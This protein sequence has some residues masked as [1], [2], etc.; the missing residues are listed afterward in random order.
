MVVWPQYL[1]DAPSSFEE[2]PPQVSI[3]SP[4]AVGLPKTRRLYTSNVRTFRVV[5]MFTWRQL[6]DFKA[7]Y[8]VELDGGV[9]EF[10]GVDWASYVRAEVRKMI[11]N[12]SIKYRWMA[13]EEFEASFTELVF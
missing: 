4:V 8:N 11:P 10:L 6:D 2:T 13:G 12:D 9:N 5:Y 7:W 1:P 3:T